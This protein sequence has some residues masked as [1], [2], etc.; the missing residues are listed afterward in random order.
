MK[1]DYITKIQE[2]ILD[3]F[4]GTCELNNYKMIKVDSS[5]DKHLLKNSLIKDIHKATEENKLGKVYYHG[6]VAKES[7]TLELG[8]LSTQTDI[9]RN[10]ELINM[11]VKFLDNLG[12]EEITVDIKGEEELIDNLETL[13]IVTTSSDEILDKKEDTAYEIYVEDEIIITGFSNQKE[14]ISYFTVD[15]DRLM[16]RDNYIIEDIPLDAYI[17]PESDDVKSDAFVIASNLKDAGFK[18]EVDYYNRQEKTDS[19][20]VIKFNSNDIKNYRVKIIDTKTN[21]AQE[22][23]IDSIIEV[24]AFM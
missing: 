3:T 23:D 2:Y 22:I 24:L 6:L 8:A 19:T 21:E 16:T 7:E 1:K 5:D 14:N 20:Y 9:Y 10:G 12:L 13:D 11:A 18:V 15:L 17:E 4:K